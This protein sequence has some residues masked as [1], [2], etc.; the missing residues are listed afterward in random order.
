MDRTRSSDELRPGFGTDYLRPPPPAALMPTVPA[1]ALGVIGVARWSEGSLSVRVPLKNAMAGPLFK[2]PV[3]FRH[4]AARGAG[5]FQPHMSP[6]ARGRSA[7]RPADGCRRSGTPIIALARGSLRISSSEGLEAGAGQDPRQGRACQK[8]DIGCDEQP[9]RMDPAAARW[10]RTSAPSS[11][12][13]ADQHMS[14]FHR[15]VRAASACAALDRPV[16]RGRWYK[17]RPLRSFGPRAGRRIS[18]KSAAARQ[19]RSAK[20]PWPS[21]RLSSHA[22][23]RL[24]RARPRGQDHQ[25]ARGRSERSAMRDALPKDDS[26]SFIRLHPAACPP[27]AWKL[28]QASMVAPI[29]GR[30]LGRFADLQE[31]TRARKKLPQIDAGKR[32]G[33]RVRP[34]HEKARDRNPHHL[35]TGSASAPDARWPAA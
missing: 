10:R 2:D 24:R 28:R 20:L 4:E 29:E 1:Q 35:R 13:F 16:V 32:H 3:R 31:D 34:W 5:A 19:R 12:P 15:R 21:A 9:M 33:H 17:G 14:E 11:P 26:R 22:Y 23:A 25:P 27:R 8:R 18:H 6:S 7:D 30:S